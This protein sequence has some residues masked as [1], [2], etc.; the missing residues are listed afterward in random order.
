MT[1]RVF[2]SCPLHFLTF[3]TG[4][5]QDFLQNSPQLHFN[6]KKVQISYCL[7]DVRKIDIQIKLLTKIIYLN[8][9]AFQFYL[10]LA[11]SIIIFLITAIEY[12]YGIV[13][14]GKFTLRKIK[15][16]E[17]PRVFKLIIGMQILFG[18]ILLV[19]SIY[20]FYQ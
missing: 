17:K 9:M 13:L 3:L 15:R 10:T 4:E 16:E 6:G 12:R 8:D 11:V 18:I 2:K 14:L 20:I 7:M 19:L 1:N 5:K